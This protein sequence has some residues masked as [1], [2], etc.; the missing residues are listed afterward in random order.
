MDLPQIYTFD[1]MRIVTFTLR[2]G[3]RFDFVPDCFGIGEG[4]SWCL[5][6]DTFLQPLVR[7]PSAGTHGAIVPVDQLIDVVTGSPAICENLQQRIVAACSAW[8]PD[9]LVEFNVALHK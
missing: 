1:P 3:D 2:C 4:D 6:V 5:F 9:V 7:F 8:T